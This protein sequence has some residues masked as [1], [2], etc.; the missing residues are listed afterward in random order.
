MRDKRQGGRKQREKKQG[1]MGMAMFC[2]SENG[3]AMERTM[4]SKAALEKVR[5]TWKC[6]CA[7]SPENALRWK[8]CGR[9]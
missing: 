3:D 8:Q 5:G 1:E 7:V 6:R 4:Q 2:F 9:G